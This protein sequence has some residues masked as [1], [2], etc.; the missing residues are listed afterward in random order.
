[1]KATW[2][3]PFVIVLFVSNSGVQGAAPSTPTVYKEE[4]EALKQLFQRAHQARGSFLEG[5]CTAEEYLNSAQLADNAQERWY[6]SHGITMQPP[7][8]QDPESTFVA[9]Q[10]V[11]S[12]FFEPSAVR[13]AHDDIRWKNTG[14]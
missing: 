4:P 11:H 7:E 8:Q 1:M 2:F 9:W 6:N 12:S 5:L 14:K 10:G 13:L 3:Y